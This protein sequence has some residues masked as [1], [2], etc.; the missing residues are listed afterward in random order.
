MEH[1]SKLYEKG[2][3]KNTNIFKEYE[4]NPNLSP[5][6]IKD[7]I[8]QV[9]IEN[10]IKKINETD[11]YKEYKTRLIGYD[12][13]LLSEQSEIMKIKMNKNIVSVFN[14]LFFSFF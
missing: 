3:Y 4:A 7:Q 5:S 10:K 1:F 6:Y 12:L 2:M 11:K 8:N 9:V 14:I 13:S